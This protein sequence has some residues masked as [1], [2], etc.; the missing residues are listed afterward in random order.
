MVDVLGKVIVY[1]GGQ[2]LTVP[3]CEFF[4]A[5]DT[6]H[7]EIEAPQ[8]AQLPRIDIYYL[9]DETQIHAWTATYEQQNQIKEQICLKYNNF[10]GSFKRA[11]FETK[12]H[13]LIKEFIC[14]LLN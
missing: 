9:S 4:I 13:G 1:D 2:P 7:I 8:E 6:T 11:Y 10:A 12:K 14:K 3:F 5:E